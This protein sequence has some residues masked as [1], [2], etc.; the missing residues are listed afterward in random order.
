MPLPVLTPDQKSAVHFA[1]LEITAI[2]ME[3]EKVTGLS[4]LVRQIRVSPAT[5]ETQIFLATQRRGN[6]KVERT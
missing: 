1:E 5:L 6:P 3:L 2:L 4:I